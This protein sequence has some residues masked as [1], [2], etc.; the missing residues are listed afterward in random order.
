MPTAVVFGRESPEELANADWNRNGNST[1]DSENES[2]NRFMKD[3][4]RRTTKQVLAN[5]NGKLHLFVKPET[6][7]SAASVSDLRC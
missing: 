4:S 5:R 7:L 2:V 6:R 3:T 1:G